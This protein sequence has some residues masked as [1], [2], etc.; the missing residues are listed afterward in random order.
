MPMKYALTVLKSKKRAGFHSMHCLRTE[1]PGSTSLS[2]CTERER[3]D[4]PIFRHREVEEHQDFK[5]DSGMISEVES[6]PSQAISPCTTMLVILGCHSYS[7][8]L[9]AF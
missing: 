3:C 9:T 2:R 1:F 6:F 7:A 5:R 8:W 4:I